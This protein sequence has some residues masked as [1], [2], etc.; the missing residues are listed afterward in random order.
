MLREMRDFRGKAVAQPNAFRSRI[1]SIPETPIAL[2]SDLDEHQREKSVL[3]LFFIVTLL[4]FLGAS[5]PAMSLTSRISSIFFQ[6]PS[7]DA[8]IQSSQHGFAESVHEVNSTRQMTMATTGEIALEGEL[9]DEL[10]RPPYLHVCLLCLESI[11]INR[12]CSQCLLVA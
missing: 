11:S 12:C 7:S 1:F 2:S 5:S 10:K 3:F 8:S 9:D 4:S 6:G